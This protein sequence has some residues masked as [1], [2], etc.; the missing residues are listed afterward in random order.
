MARQARQKPNVNEGD[1]SLTKRPHDC[2]KL[3]VHYPIRSSRHFVSFARLF[4]SF[5]PANVTQRTMIGSMTLRRFP[6]R[7]QISEFCWGVALFLFLL[8]LSFGTGN[9]GIIASKRCDHLLVTDNVSFNN[10]GS[11]LMLHKSCDDSIVRGTRKAC[12]F[13]LLCFRLFPIVVE[14]PSFSRMPSTWAS[15]RVSLACQLA[16][17]SRSRDSMYYDTAW[18]ALKRKAK[19]VEGVDS[20]SCTMLFYEACSPFGRHI[21][22]ALLLDSLASSYHS[23]MEFYAIVRSRKCM[24]D[25]VYVALPHGLCHDC[26]TR[27]TFFTLFYVCA[28]QLRAWRVPGNELYDNDAGFS[29]V[30]TSRTVV[31]MNTMNTNKW[32]IRVLVGSNDN[33]VRKRPGVSSP[34]ADL[35]TTCCSFAGEAC[36]QAL[37]F[38]MLAA[39]AAFKWIIYSD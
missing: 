12:Y 30:E 27:H 2:T 20:S 35:T 3:V 4:F 25:T 29:L 24:Q 37:R 13:S 32:G 7:V 15:W 36:T 11:G 14:V 9:H 5:D 19:Y 16:R 22:P 33:E 26:G 31:T 10:T 28:W 39:A 18:R 1:T 38:N 8:R 21:R 6:A 23:I 17:S 34:W